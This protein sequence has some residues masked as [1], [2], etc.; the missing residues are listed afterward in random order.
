[1]SSVCLYPQY[2]RKRN[3]H[4]NF[5]NNTGFPGSGSRFKSICQ[6]NNETSGSVQ[7]KRNCPLSRFGSS[8]LGSNY[9]IFE[10]STYFGRFLQSPSHSTPTCL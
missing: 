2:S 9:S 10:F 3:F 1:M 4:L 7:V 6:L 8:C 5:L